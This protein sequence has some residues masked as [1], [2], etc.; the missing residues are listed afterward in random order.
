MTKSN[1]PHII[2]TFAD[3]VFTIQI[4]RPDKKNALL[5]GMYKALAEGIN[6][7]N[8]QDEVNAI[9]IRGLDDCFTSGN[10]VNSFVGQEAEQADRPSVG[11]M[12]A[13]NESRKPIVAAISGLAIGIGTTMLFHCDL[14]YASK[15]CFLQLPFARLGLCPEAGSSYLLPRQVGQ[16][17]AME[18]LLLGER[19]DAE[20][21]QEYGIVNKVLPQS[22]YLEFAMNQAQALAA[23][24][25]DAVQTS[26]AL[27]KRG[28]SNA[29][30]DTIS[31]E[32][33]QFSRLLQTDD[34][35]AIMQAF[36]DKRKAG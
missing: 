29:T 16:L 22:E 12:Q 36:V 4:N 34:A 6:L 26:K 2:Y 15:D 19:F 18:L 17:R 24:P 1:D 35:Q 25:A 3:K 9:L 28:V 30:Q 31:I 21:A 20:R 23:L 11:F 5:P 10:D 33:K 27:I 32:L 8:E 13:L 14:V 7:A